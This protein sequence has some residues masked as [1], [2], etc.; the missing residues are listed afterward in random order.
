MAVISTTQEERKL[1]V[2]ILPPHLL[3]AGKIKE[4]S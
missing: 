1:H 2:T 4:A 3:Y